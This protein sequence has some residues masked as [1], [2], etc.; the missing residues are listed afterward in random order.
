[1]DI[2]CD[3]LGHCKDKCCI[4]HITSLVS[5]GIFRPWASTFTRL[6]K[7]YSIQC[8]HFVWAHHWLTQIA[9][10]TEIDSIFLLINLQA[11]ILCKL[12]HL[13]NELCNLRGVAKG[14]VLH[15]LCL[16]CWPLCVCLCLFFGCLCT[17]KRC[18][19][20]VCLSVII[21]S[22]PIRARQ[23]RA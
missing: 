18:S 8:L 16:L 6:E 7:W 10:F 13:F 3:H 22:L 23:V 1:M 17:H 15:F 14:F 4:Y 9:A 2:L 21:L 12:R 5:A 20:C 19:I 11:K